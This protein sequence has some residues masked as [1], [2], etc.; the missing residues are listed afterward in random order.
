MKFDSLA[1]KSK[2][3][4]HADCPPAVRKAKHIS[5]AIMWRA[6]A[7]ALGG[8]RSDDEDDEIIDMT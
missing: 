4:G 6:A 3:T 1:N 7:A 5:R 2:P 8:V